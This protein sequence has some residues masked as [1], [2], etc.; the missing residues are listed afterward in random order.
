MASLSSP[1]GHVSCFYRQQFGLSVLGKEVHIG[2]FAV[3]D[4]LLYDGEQQAAL[5]LYRRRIHRMG[6]GF[7][8]LLMEGKLLMEHPALLREGLQLGKS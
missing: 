1:D 2:V 4:H 3:P 7:D 6:E 8:H 5:F